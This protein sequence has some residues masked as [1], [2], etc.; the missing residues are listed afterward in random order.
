MSAECPV[1]HGQDVTF[2]DLQNLQRDKTPIAGIARQIHAGTYDFSEHDQLLAS[3]STPEEARVA[4]YRSGKPVRNAI[5]SALS[6]DVVDAALG[7]RPER[8]P[9]GLVGTTQEVFVSEEIGTK[10]EER[11][12]LPGLSYADPY[13]YIRDGIT[14]ALRTELSSQ[15]LLNYYSFQK[16]YDTPTTRAYERYAQWIDIAKRFK[17]QTTDQIGFIDGGITND[18]HFMSRTLQAIPGA[19]KKRYGEDAPVEKIVEIA[20][21]SDTFVI[22]TSQ[23]IRPTFLALKRSFFVFTRMGIDP[24]NL[25]TIVEDAGKEHI[26]L[27]PD[28]YKVAKGSFAPEWIDEREMSVRTNCPAMVSIDGKGSSIE[29]L[30][31]W[32][33]EL[34]QPVWEQ[35]AA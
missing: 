28:A 34:I 31:D 4:W 21:N 7:H 24:K 25:Y 6:F 5:V 2:K 1:P 15:I 29:R 30:W 13:A 18:T 32:Y 14:N 11:E 35:E 10:Y 27:C 9:L 26:D 16:G 3:I 17:V 12:S 19:V 8:P 20:K 22:H 33:L 23:L